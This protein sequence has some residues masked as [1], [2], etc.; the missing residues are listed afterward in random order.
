MNEQ[1]KY[2][3]FVKYSGKQDWDRPFLSVQ[4]LSIRPPD[5]YASKTLE[6][7]RFRP[8][9]LYVAYLQEGKINPKEEKLIRGREVSILPENIEQ[10]DAFLD[11]EGIDLRE[12]RVFQS[13]IIPDFPRKKKDEIWI[14]YAGINKIEIYNPL[15]PRKINEIGMHKAIPVGEII[16]IKMRQFTGIRQKLIDE[17]PDL[18]KKVKRHRAPEEINAVLQV[19]LDVTDNYANLITGHYS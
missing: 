17:T 14:A 1:I 7:R 2:E 8:S 15:G 3:C 13:I 19:R 6:F 10:V 4:N 9:G 12:W 18:L 5:V 11:I 16:S